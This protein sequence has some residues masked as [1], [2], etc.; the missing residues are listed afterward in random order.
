MHITDRQRYPQAVYYTDECM[1]CNYSQ[2]HRIEYEG[3]RDKN[4]SKTRPTA[5]GKRTPLPTITNRDMITRVEIIDRTKPYDEGGGRVYTN[6]EV[7][8]AWISEQDEGR[9]LKIFIN[10][11]GNKEA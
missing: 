11:S 1:D 6:Y 5:K 2:I 8:D 10:E 4:G 7:K 3:G 9:T